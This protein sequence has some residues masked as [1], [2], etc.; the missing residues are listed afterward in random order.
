MITRYQVEHPPDYK[1]WAP[2]SRQMLP[3]ALE[4]LQRPKCTYPPVADPDWGFDMLG[5]GLIMMQVMLLE[6]L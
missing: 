4:N 1:P 2:P 5:D 6:K 3:P